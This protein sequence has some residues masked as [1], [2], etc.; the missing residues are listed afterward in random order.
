MLFSSKDQSRLIVSWKLN[1]S[2]LTDV[3]LKRLRMPWLWPEW[4]FNLLPE[5]REHARC[6]EIAHQ[7]TG[8]V[9]EDRAKAFQASEIQSKR[10]AFLGKS[11]FV[12]HSVSD[13][14]LQIYFSNKCMRNNYHCGIFKKKWIHLCLK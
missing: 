4:M 13:S 6:L 2:R 8:K 14:I 1:H 11:P 3:I 5:G 7:F 10:S 12:S 9:I